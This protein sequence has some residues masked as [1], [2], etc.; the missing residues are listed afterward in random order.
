MGEAKR[1]RDRGILPAPRPELTPEQRHQRGRAQAIRRHGELPAIRVPVHGR[2]FRIIAV[3]GDDVEIYERSYSDRLE[4][5]PDSKTT[6][7][8]KKMFRYYGPSKRVTDPEIVKLVLEHAEKRHIRRE[9]A[10]GTPPAAE[11]EAGENSNAE[12]V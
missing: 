3:S 7:P 11:P 12:E 4:P 8:A 5:D 9:Y 10:V 1:K 2:E 6:P